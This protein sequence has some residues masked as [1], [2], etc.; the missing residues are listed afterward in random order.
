[1]PLRERCPVQ[2]RVAM[3]LYH[4][5]G[6]YTVEGLAGRYGISRETFYVWKRL[7]ESG[8]E[9]WYEEF[10]RAPDRCPHATPEELVS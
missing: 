7:R 6:V 4:D 10:S 5:T 3:F 2:E 8:A 9:D 1:M